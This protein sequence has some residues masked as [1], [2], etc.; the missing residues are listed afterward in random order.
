MTTYKSSNAFTTSRRGIF[1][2]LSPAKTLDLSPLQSDVLS[3]IESNLSEPSCDLAKTRQLAEILQSKSQNEL[4]KLLNVSDKISSTVKEYYGNFDMYRKTGDGLRNNLKPAI[5]SFDG[6]AFKGIHPSTCSRNTLQYMQ[7]NL[8]IVDPLF[9]ALKPLDQIQPY[10]L[11]MATKAIVKELDTE[12]KTLAEWWKDSITCNILN[13]MKKCKC[14][15]LVNL[16]SDEYASA[17]DAE[18]LL[19]NDWKFIK[20]AFQQEGKVVA[21][22]AKRARGLMVRY[23]SEN[24]ITN[25]QDIQN[26]DLEGYRYCRERSDEN[27]F[28]FDRLKNY[29]DKTN[30]TAGEEPTQKEK[31]R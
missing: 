21:V 7:T 16:A 28:V 29:M 3:G 5:F 14:D 19:K 8:R 31:R 27:T 25:I 18:Q 17:I 23:I 6:P 24:E 12:V 10:R 4:K 13:D 15:V 11:E 22:H 9:G 1:M 30:D 20:I 26:F 2:I